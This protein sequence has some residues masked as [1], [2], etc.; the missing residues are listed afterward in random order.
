[1]DALSDAICRAVEMHLAGRKV[2][3]IRDRGEWMRRI[4]EVTLDGG[5]I[6]FVKLSVHPEYLESTNHEVQVEQILR[7][8][9]LPVSRVLVTDR[10]CQIVPYPYLIQERAGGTRLGDLLEQVD[11]VK[12][13]EIYITLGAF[14]RR[15][16][17]IRGQRSEIWIK[18][19]DQPLGSPN[20]YMYQA[21]IIN[22]SGQRALK[23][24]RISTQIY[25]RIVRVWAENMD[26]LKS[27]PAVLVHSSPFLWTIYLERQEGAWQVT[28]IMSLGD[29]LWWDA[30]HDLAYLQYPPFG[31]DDPTRWGAFQSSYGPLPERKRI[32]L[33][34]LLHR[35]CAAM[36]GFAEP[37]SAANQAWRAHCLEDLDKFLDAIEHC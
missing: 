2:T 14:Y 8:H 17:A 10:S 18:S 37:H 12:A 1:M 19:P 11:E 32:L 27:H 13:L 7:E 9:G 28:K 23:T 20:E 4:Y 16:H 3:A 5:E 30:A 21:E 35:L 26:Y 31:Q 33:Y 6:V 15:L 36:G 29:L 24:G 25:E 22:G 34:V